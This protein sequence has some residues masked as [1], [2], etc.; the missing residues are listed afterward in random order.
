MAVEML[1]RGCREGE[2]HV[3]LSAF[4]SWVVTSNFKTTS[5]NFTMRGVDRRRALARPG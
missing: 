3:F 1:Q 5:V 4:N 2:K